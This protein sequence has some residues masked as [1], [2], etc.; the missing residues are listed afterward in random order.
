MLGV[1]HFL[2]LLVLSLKI[3]SFIFLHN[4]FQAATIVIT[5]RLPPDTL[6][7]DHP[8]PLPTAFTVISPLLFLMVDEEGVVVAEEDETTVATMDLLVYP[9]SYEM[10]HPILPP[11]TSNGPL[12]A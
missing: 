5:A 10:S 9:S 4:S 12:V 3:D 1:R 2:M 6:D 7:M 8:F 11:K